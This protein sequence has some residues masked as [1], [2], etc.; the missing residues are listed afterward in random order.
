MDNLNNFR[1]QKDEMFSNTSDSPLT[2]EQKT[3]FSGLKYFPFSEKF[4]FS[5]LELTP[6]EDQSSINIQTSKGDS[7][8]YTRAGKVSFSIDNTSCHLT[9]F[10]GTDNSLFLPFKDSTSSTESYPAGRYLEIE[11]INGKISLDFNY[12]YNPYC[13]YNDNW[14]CPLCPPE[15]ILPVRIEAGEKKFHD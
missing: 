7:D 14:R 11:N 3:S 4:I 9:I 8:Q 5:N 12:A 13:S 1:K 15:N 6:H 2:P 10:R